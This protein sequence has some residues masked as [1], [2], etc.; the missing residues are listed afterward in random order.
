MIETLWLTAIWLG[1]TSAALWL[2]GC[3]ERRLRERERRLAELERIIAALEK[4]RER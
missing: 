4:A 3:T 1:M 2:A